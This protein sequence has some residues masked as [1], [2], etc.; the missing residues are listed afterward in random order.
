MIFRPLLLSSSNKA[1]PI[2]KESHRHKGFQLHSTH[3]YHDLPPRYWKRYQY[4][5]QFVQLV[6]SKTPKVT[7]YTEEAKC[8]LMENG[9]PSD[10]E[11]CFYNGWL[12]GWL[13]GRWVG[14]L[15]G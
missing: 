7:L 2:P 6:R 8:M 10:L 4:A 3:S 15:V 9:P 5:A 11:A 1:T 14:G 13:V 12:V